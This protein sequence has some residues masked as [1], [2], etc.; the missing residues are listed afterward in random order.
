MDA[1]SMP[2]VRGGVVYFVDTRGGVTARDETTGLRRWDATDL[3][4]GSGSPVLIG[5]VL[6][7]A[8]DDGTVTALDAATGRQVWQQSLDAGATAALNG[9]DDRIVIGTEAG[10]RVLAADAPGT[11]LYKV[12]AGGPI[13]RSPAVADGV[14]YAATDGESADAFLTAFDLRTGEIR[15]HVPLGTGETSTPAVSNGVVYVVHGPFDQSAPHELLAIDAGTGHRLWAWS[16]PTSER[17]FVGSVIDDLVYVVGVDG[18]VHVIDVKTH[19]ARELYRA[20]GTIGALS[21][22]VGD[23]LYVSSEDGVVQAV[24]RS[25][26]AV[27]WRFHVGGRPTMPVVIDGRVVVGNDVGQAISLSASAP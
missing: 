15:W 1:L 21:T 24:D 7:V 18:A 5:T 22:V 6:V 12:D 4:E 8:A 3:G 14:V 10:V 26:G 11:L 17:F 13:R 19:A 2:L 9:S 25:S 23:S 27:R 16:P 20:G